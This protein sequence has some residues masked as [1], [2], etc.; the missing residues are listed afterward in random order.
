VWLDRPT[1]RVNNS[2]MFRCRLSFERRR[3]AYFTGRSSSARHNSGSAQ[4]PH[5][6][7]RL[8]AAGNLG[9]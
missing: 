4:R 5:R 9:Q 7:G 1:G 3:I 8:P 2:V 6:P